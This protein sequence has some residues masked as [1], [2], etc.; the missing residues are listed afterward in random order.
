[1][2]PLV[3]HASSRTERLLPR[4]GPMEHLAC[5]SSTT[6]I[7]HL[8]DGCCLAVQGKHVGEHLYHNLYCSPKVCGLWRGV[9]ASKAPDKMGTCN[10]RCFRI[11]P[12]LLLTK[13]LFK[14]S[15]LIDTFFEYR[16]CVFDTVVKTL[17]LSQRT[18]DLMSGLE[19]YRRSILCDLSRSLDTYHQRKRLGITY[20]NRTACHDHE[21]PSKYAC[22]VETDDMKSHRLPGGDEVQS[23]RYDTRTLT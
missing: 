13:S 15:V 20:H 11:S 2:K 21:N 8:P 3:S 23:K 4:W 10:R 5:Q 7:T 17:H 6:D 22:G 12:S 19:W 1:M 9:M 16:G 14:E 18:W